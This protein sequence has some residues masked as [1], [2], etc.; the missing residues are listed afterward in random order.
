MTKVLRLDIS[1]DALV[2]HRR[3]IQ[4]KYSVHET[5]PY[6]KMRKIQRIVKEDTLLKII[7]K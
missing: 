2:Q 5:Q 3:T 6:S 7:S 1:N 4:D